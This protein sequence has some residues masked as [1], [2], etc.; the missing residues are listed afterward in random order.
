[1]KSK[2]IEHFRARNQVKNDA[3]FVV[4]A[5]AKEPT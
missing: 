4:V 2:P 5:K 1:V 3:G